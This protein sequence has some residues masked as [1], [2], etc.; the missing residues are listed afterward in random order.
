MCGF[1]GVVSF[2]KINSTLLQKSNEFSVCRGPDNLTALNGESNLNHSLFFNRLSIIDLSKKANQPFISNK[3]NSILMFNGEIYNAMDLR[4]EYLT[5]SYKFESKNSDTETLMAGLETYGVE[6]VNLL[7]GQFSFFYWQKDKKKIYLARDRLGQ[8]PLYFY[9]KENTLGFASNL[10]S[11]I[12]YFKDKEIDPNSIGQ[13]LSYGVVFSENNIFKNYKKLCPATF[14]EI[15]YSEN[16]FNKKFEKYW[17]IGEFVDN[18]KFVQDEFLN[19]FSKSIEKRMVSDVPIANFLSGGIDS[20]SIV[21]NM[22]EKKYEI[23]TFSVL[24]KSPNLDE[25]QYIKNVVSKYKTN[26]NAFVVDDSISTET[27][28]NSI[29]SLDEPFG[30]PSIVLTYFLSQEISNYYKVA[31]SG[32][33]GDELLGG[34]ERLKNIFKKVN[35]SRNLISKAHIIYPSFLGT[36]TFF[37]SKS[38]NLELAYRSFLEDSNF[39]NLLIKNDKNFPLKKI[40]FDEIDDEY[41]KFIISDY[42]YYLSDQMLLKIDRASMANSLEIRSPF[43][44]HSLIEYILSHDYQYHENNYQKKPL[45]DY[46]KKDFDTNFLNR[47]KQGFVFDYKNWVFNNIEM[48][49]SKIFQN[50][51]D[52]ND[53]IN[54][55]DVEKIK[56]FKSRINALRLWKLYVLSIYLEETSSL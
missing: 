31:I 39:Y 52:K 32:D 49:E 47:P 25:S 18:K 9:L 44:D 1:T 23:N 29:N 43:V 36:G 22:F 7:E 28:I 12:S 10:K 13:Y 16:K 26:H 35:F 46:L 33:G 14:L 2:D 6:F 3:S 53:Y 11:L 4:R 5:N 41:K 54:F 8:K 21:K 45:Y 15:D 20:T 17:E 40:T 37:K 51:C 30:D 50:L 38:S 55:E 42:K 56:V 24:V 34:Y 19:L 27:V 48:I